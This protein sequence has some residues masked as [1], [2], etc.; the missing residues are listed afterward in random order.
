M[1]FYLFE[2][3]IL[4]FQRFLKSQ[5]L[6]LGDLDGFWGPKTEKAATEFDR[7]SKEIRAQFSEFDVR[8]E[9]NIM[10][11]NFAAQ[12]EARQFMGRL[13]DGGIRAKIISGTRTYDEQNKLYKKGR[14][15]NPGPKVTY[16]RGGRSKHNF[17]IAWD[18]GIF[19]ASGEYVT[20]NPPYQDAAAVG[21]ID[22]I[23]WGGN[24]QNFVDMPHYQLNLGISVTEVR[25]RFEAGKSLIR[26]A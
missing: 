9:R 13:R 22:T 21:L 5:G 15:G 2:N 3:D 16:A 10:S 1:S 7:E 6:Y 11:L 20:E 23:E 24:W 8:S 14:W 17:G 18:I 26:F 25:E 19:T 4:F 12:R